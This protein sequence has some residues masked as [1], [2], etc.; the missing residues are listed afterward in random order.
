MINW[1]FLAHAFAVTWMTGVI[2]LV[3]LVHYPAFSDIQPERFSEFHAFHSRSI[4]WVVAPPMLIQLLSALALVFQSPFEPQL[5]AIPILYLILT[6]LVFGVTA[7]ASVPAH[8]VL[9]LGFDTTTHATLVRTNWL[10]TLTWSAHLGLCLYGLYR[11][12]GGLE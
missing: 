8:Q 11:N 4:T 2:W 6:L 10:R 9:A 1:I 7:F 3:Q 5:R 12:K